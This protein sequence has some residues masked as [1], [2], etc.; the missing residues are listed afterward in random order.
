M[1]GAA[2]A[3][4]GIDAEYRAV[5][6]APGELAQA[7][8]RLAEPPFLGANVTV[9]HKEAVVPLMHEL[10]QAA[11]SV[12]AVNT[13][14]NRAGRLVGHNTDGAGFLQALD[15]LP[16]GT[17]AAETGAAPSQAGLAGAT[18]V[19]LGAG[20][21]ARAVVNALAGAGAHVHVHNRNLTRA[22][23]LVADLSTGGGASVAVAQDVSALLPQADLL[24]NT[25]SV[26]MS[27]GPDPSGLPLVTAAQ[28]ATL[29]ATARVVDLVY[30]PAQTPLIA[31]ASGLGLL[32]QNGLPMLVWQGALAFAEWT[33]RAAPVDVM[34]AAAERALA[35]SP[36]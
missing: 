30:R 7:V 34:R 24:V 20:G 33:G 8:A 13:I 21:A 26:G 28:L 32:T 3:A 17:G 6:V 2:F 10:T 5:D 14:V 36:S 1:H 23:S 19:V 9:P 25:T 4:L 15:E 12:G 22:E 27:G 11:R 31:V 16:R 18:C 35:A 29:P